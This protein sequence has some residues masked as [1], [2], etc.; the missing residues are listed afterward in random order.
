VTLLIESLFSV[1]GKVALVTGGSSGIGQMIATALAANGVKVYI[2]G[3]KKE[4][5]E[6]A[7][8]EISRY[9]TCIGLMADLSRV[10]ECERLAAE[11]ASREPK[12]HILINNA[13][14]SWGQPLDEYTEAGWERVMNLNLKGV[15]FLTQKLLPLLDAAATHEDNARVIS[16]SSVGAFVPH[17]NAYAYN[18]S[19]AALEQLTRML[20]RSFSGRNITVNAMSPG[21]YPTKM[22]APLGDE[23]RDAWLANT[24]VGRLGTVEDAGGLII[25]LCSRAGAYINGRTIITDGGETL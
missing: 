15:F 1:A 18:T 2:A 7:V 4:R 12:L 25:F 14:N 21:W 13:G 6:S 23:A 8:A 16:L 5:L 17:G 19:K 9:G 10:D 20:A 11:L 22:N 3:R 24:P